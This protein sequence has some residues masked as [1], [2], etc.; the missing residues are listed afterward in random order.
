MF[1]RLS[2]GGQQHAKYWPTGLES[3]PIIVDIITELLSSYSVTNSENLSSRLR[4]D[5]FSREYTYSKYTSVN[6]RVP[7]RTDSSEGGSESVS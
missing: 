2:A 3:V 7:Y 6:Q 5:N 1:V 4:Q